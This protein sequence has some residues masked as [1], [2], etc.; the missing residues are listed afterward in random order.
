[1]MVGWDLRG[2]KK[3]LLKYWINALKFKE[4]GLNDPNFGSQRGWRIKLGE[5]IF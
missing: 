2:G 3:K 1:M 5:P 4:F